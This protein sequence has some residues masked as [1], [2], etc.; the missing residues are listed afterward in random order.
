[1]KLT[2]HQLQTGGLKAGDLNYRQSTLWAKA[3]KWKIKVVKPKHF[4][5]AEA[6]AI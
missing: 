3:A 2:G 5:M 4:N 6:S 1:V